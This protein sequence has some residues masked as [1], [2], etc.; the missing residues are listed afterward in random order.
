MKFD[1]SEIGI[2]SGLQYEC[3]TTTV[4]KEGV[5]NAGA[6]AFEY[7]GDDKVKCHIFEGSKTLKNI[8]DTNEYV[9]NI[10]Q[11]PL[12]FTYATLDCLGDEYYTDDES[13]AI[14]KNTPAYIIVDVENVEIKTPENFPIKGDS[15]IYFIYGKIRKLVV[16][17]ER[18][19]AFNR[20][21][22]ALIESLVNFSRYKIVDEEKRKEYMDKLIE[23]QR[24]IN[25]VSDEKTKKA[26]SDLKSEYEKY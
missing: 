24:V 23:N 1:L 11:N 26:I 6:F 4:N 2:K 5:K 20:G 3:I 21:M 8:L 25:K 19:A 16:N 22:S 10:T 13:I 9:V 12:V 17:D 14:I 7:L 15:N 18:A